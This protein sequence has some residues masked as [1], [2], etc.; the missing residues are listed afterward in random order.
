[1]PTTIPTEYVVAIVIGVVVAIA[2]VVALVLGFLNMNRRKSEQRYGEPPAWMVK[3][4]KAMHAE[5]TRRLEANAAL[6]DLV[7]E[8][9]ETEVDGAA[10]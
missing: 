5:R 9:N 2:I 10:E 8:H 1:M 3:R 6:V 7:A 4:W